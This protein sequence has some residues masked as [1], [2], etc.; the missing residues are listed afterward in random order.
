MQNG[1]V[2]SKPRLMNDNRRLPRGSSGEQKRESFKTADREGHKSHPQASATYFF[3][4]PPSPL[5]E[6]RQG[7]GM[8][9]RT[10]QSKGK[11][12]IFYLQLSFKEGLE[13]KH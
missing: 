10:P 9:S 7:V 3:V 5:R 4:C 8:A 2:L 12:N 11:L 1:S 6:V 13:S